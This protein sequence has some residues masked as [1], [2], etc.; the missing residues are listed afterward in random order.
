[1]QSVSQ[2]SVLSPLSAEC[3]REAAKT[4]PGEFTGIRHVRG[5][6]SMG[7]MSDPDSGGS[8]CSRSREPTR[9]HPRL[10]LTRTAA[11]PPSPC[12]SAGR[13][14]STASTPCL[15]RRDGPGVTRDPEIA[16]RRRED[17]LCGLRLPR[18]QSFCRSALCAS[19]LADPFPSLAQVLD[20]DDVLKSV[21]EVET[22]QEASSPKIARD[23]PGRA[24]T[25][26]FWAH[27]KPLFPRISHT[28]RKKVP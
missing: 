25:P 18:L 8:S 12:C 11:A 20:G 26:P 2:G 28:V 13:R 21:E 6:L 24:H 23:C 4:V 7:R 17:H 15:E 16:S 5:M 14:I 1:V 22:R 19:R 27:G 3:A 9:A 10:G